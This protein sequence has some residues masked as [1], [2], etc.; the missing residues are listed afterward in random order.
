MKVLTKEGYYWRNENSIAV[1]LVIFNTGWLVN[2][3]LSVVCTKVKS[4]DRLLYFLELIPNYYNSVELTYMY[5]YDGKR[6]HQGYW[7]CTVSYLPYL[8][9]VRVLLWCWCQ[10]EKNKN[11]NNKQ[12]QTFFFKWKHPSN[13]NHNCTWN[14]KLFYIWYAFII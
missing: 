3:R 5:I 11:N 8:H 2:K 9:V 12:T 13:L 4:S 6:F 10:I 14:I 7:L 1:F